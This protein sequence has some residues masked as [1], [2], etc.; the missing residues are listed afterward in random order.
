MLSQDESRLVKQLGILFLGILVCLELVLR[1]GVGLGNP[2][3]AVLDSET[4]Y[5]LVRSVSYR[6][7]GNL[8]EI[9]AQGMR[10]RD[11]PP[12]LKPQERRL[13]LIGDSVIYGGHFLTQSETIAAQMESHL[14]QQSDCQITVLP[15]AVS[16]WGPVNQAAFLSRDGTH[17]A[18]GAAILVSAH[19]LYDVPQAGRNIL[20]YRTTK[21]ISA[22]HDAI[23][24]IW[25]RAFPPEQVER[26]SRAERR[27]KSLQALSK[28]HEQLRRSGIALTMIYHPTVGE[29]DAGSSSARS[30]FQKW[31]DE[32]GA[33]FVDLG[34]WSID[35]AG[36]RDNIHPNSKGAQR[37][38]E[39]L[40][41]EL[42]EVFHP[43][44]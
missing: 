14:T 33:R 41:V 12:A 3:L 22:L 15:L 25:E 11:V 34:E 36:Y 19:D 6:R 29:R 2:P 35:L 44:R 16:S 43:C 37:L 4:E 28:M 18:T 21:P 13:L 20:P 1:W 39:I 5:E 10:A 31:A 24:I 40:A 27:Q 7:W 38:A 32:V 26:L 9:N 42:E 30:G 23:T 17:G 8:I